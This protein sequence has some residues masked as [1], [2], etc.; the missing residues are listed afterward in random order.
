M[1]SPFKTR[2]MPS[3]L[4][5]LVASAVLTA[6]GSSSDDSVLDMGNTGKERM[7]VETDNY[8]VEY[9]PEASGEAIGHNT[10]ILEIRDMDG[11]LATGRHVSLKP[12]MTMS[13]GYQHGTPMGHINERSDH[14][15]QGDIY[16]LMPGG[17]SM[18]EWQLTVCIGE[19]ASM[20][21]MSMGQGEMNMSGCA[22][23]E[24]EAVLYPQV[25]MRKGVKGTLKGGEND[26]I[27]AMG[28]GTQARSYHFFKHS[29]V[30]HEGTYRAHVYIAATES[31]MSFPGL[32]P[33]MVLNADTDTELAVTEEGL[34]VQFSSD[35]GE[36]WVDA[37]NAHGGLWVADMAGMA[38][39]LQ[40]QL[41]VD[42]EMKTETGASDDVNSYVTLTMGESMGDEMGDSMDNMDGM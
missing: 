3:V 38:D 41:V 32:K 26:Q 12:L 10:F 4:S 18:G 31:M 6:C 33:D 20:G 29:A 24:E 21:G 14:Y 8:S 15:Y 40:V 23:G 19:M 34:Q 28:D 36:T 7:L 2:I 9:I 1:I 13:S 25:A 17:P 35:D 37:A 30:Q 16:Y 39:K 22:E 27:P 11:N 5:V 42:D